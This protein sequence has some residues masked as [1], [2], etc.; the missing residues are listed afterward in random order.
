M[1]FLSFSRLLRWIHTFLGYYNLLAANKV[2]SR[3]FFFFFGG[4]GGFLPKNTY[5]QVFAEFDLLF[6]SCVNDRFKNWSLMKQARHM[7]IPYMPMLVPPIKWT[8]YV[9]LSFFFFS[10]CAAFLYFLVSSLCFRT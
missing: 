3:F 8:G 5:L 4:R 10:Q 1:G 2:V 7:V 6:Y 9:N